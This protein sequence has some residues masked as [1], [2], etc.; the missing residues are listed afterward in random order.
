M[1]SR[2]ELQAQQYKFDKYNSV[3]TSL[4]SQEVAGLYGQSLLREINELVNLY[5]IYEKGAF[6]ITEGSNGDYI[7]SDLRYKHAKTLID[8]QARFLFSKEPDF[9]IQ[10]SGEKSDERDKAQSDLQKFLDEVLKKNK[11]KGNLVRAA[12][13]CFIAKRIAIMLNFNNKGIKINVI[14]S[15][16]FVYDTDEEGNLSKIIAFYTIHDNQNKMEQRIYKKKYYM[17][18]DNLC[19]VVEEIYDG[20]GTV[21]ETIIEDMKTKFTYIPAVVIVNGGLLGDMLG[22]SDIEDVSDY[23]SWYSRLSNADMDAERKGMNPV[24]YTIDMDSESTK[25]L[26]QGAGSYWDLSSDQ[27]QDNVS[28]QVGVLESNMSYSSSL[29]STLG[30]IKTTMYSQM[31]MPDTSSEALQGLVTSGK[32]L[33]AIYWPLI[34]RCDEKMKDWAPAFE[35]MIRTIIDGAKLYPECKTPYDNKEVPDVVFEVSVENQYPLPEDEVEEKT[36]DI[37]EVNAQTMSKKAYMKKWRGLT[38]EEADEELKQIALERQILEDS[39]VPA[40]DLQV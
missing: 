20:T 14:P 40:T 5:T 18:E 13:D 19:H 3:P 10:V 28:P 26:S 2:E 38:S 23:E 7:P 32:T 6:F 33:K 27:N 15:L 11:F 31:D 16:E 39:I 8:K 34:V 30:R 25:D 24:K 35:F 12:R 37:Q 17:G 1:E 36:I 9:S 29:D 4:I 21:V 22:V